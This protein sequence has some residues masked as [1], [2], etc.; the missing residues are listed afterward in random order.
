M[1]CL[2]CISGDLKELLASD[3]PKIMK[4]L[5]ELDECEDGS[6]V[7]FEQKGKKGK[8]KPSAYNEFIGSCM[9]SGKGMKDCA[10][11]WKREKK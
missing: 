4:I 9:K 5:D 8:R 1:P 10:G 2:K 3:D 11:N 7:G 6:S